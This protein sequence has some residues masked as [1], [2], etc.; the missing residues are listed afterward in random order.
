M[1]RPSCSVMEQKLQPP[2]QPRMSTSERFTV[3]YAGMRSVYIGCGS[4]VN[5]RS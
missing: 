3:S 5:G 2:K 1:T 4:R